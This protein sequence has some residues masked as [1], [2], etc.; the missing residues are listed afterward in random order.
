MRR[1]DGAMREVLGE[2]IAQGLKDPRIGFVT[3]T[4]VETSGDL[5]FARV[6]VSLLGNPEERQASV[7][8]LNS[9]AGLLQR[10][11]ASQL[12]MKRTPTLTF[13]ED[14]TARRAARVDEILA[15]EPEPP[16]S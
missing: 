10:R 15:N 11:V 16:A 4:D 2:A 8:G 5:Q 7:D 14:P 3:V 6:Y 9:A 12:R 13:L 1:V